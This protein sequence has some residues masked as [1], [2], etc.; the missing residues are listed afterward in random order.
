MAMIETARIKHKEINQVRVM[1]DK[2]ILTMKVFK[3]S[4]VS[5][6]EI[7]T[8]KGKVKATPVELNDKAFL[9][10]TAE[11]ISIMRS[12]YNKQK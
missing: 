3:P 5:Y 4:A 10:D 12:L 6:I 11:L 9:V 8:N 7:Y 2:A 1:A